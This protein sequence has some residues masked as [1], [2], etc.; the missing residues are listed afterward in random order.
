MT[1]LFVLLA[2]VIALLSVFGMAGFASEADIA[3]PECYQSGDLNGDGEFNTKDAIYALYSGFFGDE[4]Y[5][6]S[7]DWDFDGNGK[8]NSRDAIELLYA[9]YGM[10]DK[11]STGMVHD[12]HDPVWS[13]NAAGDS[14]S[15]SVTF[16]CGCQDAVTVVYG[17]EGYALS[18]Q[19]LEDERVEPGCL[20]AGTRMYQAVIHYDGK[21]YTSRIH[22]VAVPAKG[23]TTNGIVAVEGQEGYHGQFCAECQSY[24]D[25]VEHDWQDAG[26][27][28][29]EMPCFKP[30]RQTYVCAG[31]KAEKT[32]D[33]SLEEHNY[34]YVENGDTLADSSCC[35]YVK[36]YTCSVCPAEKNPEQRDYY[37]SHDFVATDKRAATCKVNGALIYTC[38]HCPVQ[39]EEFILSTGEEHKWNEGTAENGVITYTC[40]EDGCGK[41]K[42]AIVA[43]PDGAVSKDALNTSGEVELGNAT[44]DL[45]KVD[46][47]SLEEE[48]KL[49]VGTHDLDAVL[50]AVGGDAAAAK[51]DIKTDTVY[52]FSMTNSQGMPVQ[53][54]G[55]ITITMPYELAEG[56]DIT[57]IG[58][59]YI[60]E[61]GSLERISATWSDGSITF[62]VEHFSYYTVRRLTPAERC[63]QYGHLWTESTKAATCLVD[64]YTKQVCQ[65]CAAEQNAVVLPA[66]GSHSYAVNTEAGK[67]AT[68]LVDGFPLEECSA[69]GHQKR[70]IVKATGHTMQP[71]RLT[72]AKCGVDGEFVTGCAD[73]EYTKTEKL[74]ALVH[75]YGTEPTQ[76]VAATCTAGGYEV[77]TCV[78]CTG[79]IHKNETQPTGHTYEAGENA[80]TWSEDFT[81]A[82]VTLTCHCGSTKELKAVATVSKGTCTG[83]GSAKVVISYNNKVFSDERV[84]GSAPGHTAGESWVTNANQHYHLCAVCGDK[85]DIATHNYGEGTETKAP[86]C[87]EPGIESFF[88]GVCGYEKQQT[89][90][91]TGKHNYVDGSCADCGTQ[92]SACDHSKLYPSQFDISGFDICQGTELILHSCS[93]GKVQRL[94]VKSEWACQLEV[95]SQRQEDNVTGVPT[96]TETAKCSKCG[97][98][99]E[100]SGGYSVAED[101][102]VMYY[103]E[104]GKLTLDG[105]V[106]IQFTY[107]YPDSEYRHPPVEVLEETKLGD[108]GICDGYVRKYTCPC[109]EKVQYRGESSCEWTT[110]EAGNSQCT[111]CGVLEMGESR[112]VE[113][114]CFVDEYYTVTYVLNG[115]TVFSYTNSYRSEN[116]DWKRTDVKLH[117]D[118]CTDGL[119]ITEVCTKC[120]EQ[121]VNE[122]EN[123]VCLLTDTYDLKEYGMCGGYLKQYVCP[124]GTTYLQQHETN[125]N[126]EYVWDEER[127]MEYRRCTSCGTIMMFDGSQSEP[128]E[129]CQY[130]N[131][132]SI[133]FYDAKMVELLRGASVYIS[134]Q[135]D[136]KYTMTLLGETCEDGVEMKGVCTRCGETTKYTNHYHEQVLVEHIDLAEQGLCGGYIE[137]YA[138]ACGEETSTRESDQCNWQW[139]SNDGTIE[140]YSC[141]NCGA[142]RRTTSTKTETIDSCRDKWLYVTVIELN[143]KEVA[144]SETEGMSSHHKYVYELQLN[145]GAT[146]CEGGYKYRQRCHACGVGDD[147]WREAGNFDHYT[148]AVSYTL[149][150]GEDLCGELWLRERRCACGKS[151]E[152]EAYW[153][154]NGC[155]FTNVD[156]KYICRICGV[157]RL[158]ESTKTLVEGTTC[159]YRYSSTYTFIK[160]GKKIASYSTSYTDTEHDCISS[161]EML[162]ETCADGYYVIDKCQNCD[163]SYKYEE[164]YTDCSSHTVE[165]R[166][167]VRDNSAICGYVAVCRSSCPCGANGSVYWSVENCDFRDVELPDGKGYAEQCIHC[168]LIR[169]EK[170]VYERAP[171][172]CQVK[173]HRYYTAILNGEEVGHAELEQ[174]SYQ[175]NYIYTGEFVEGGTSCTDGYY[176]RM[177]CARCGETARDDSLRYNHETCCLYYYDLSDYGLCGGTVEAYGCVCQQEIRWQYFNDCEWE[178]LGTD[179]E[180]GMSKRYCKTCNTYAIIDSRTEYDPTECKDKGF[181]ICKL[182]R[183]GQV[184]LDINAPVRKESH[185]YLM[186]NWTLYGADCEAGYEVDLVC[187]Y[188]GKTNTGGG[189][190]HSSYAIQIIDLKAQGACSGYIEV[191]R[192][193]CGKYD[194]VN[195]NNSCQGAEYTSWREDKADGYAHYFEQHLCKDCGLKRLEEYYDVYPEGS[196]EGTRYETISFYMGEVLLYT[197]SDEEECTEHHWQV[198]NCQL[199]NPNGDCESGVIVSQSC[200]FCGENYTYETNYHEEHVQERIDLSLYGS[201]CGGY[202]ER[203][204]CACGDNQGARLSEDLDCDL[205]RVEID[206]WLKNALRESQYTSEGQNGYYSQSYIYTC[207]VTD[208]QCGMKIRYFDGWLQ[209][210]CEAV[211]YHIWQLGYDPETNTWLKEVKVPTGQRRPF[212]SYTTTYDCETV[213][214]VTYSTETGICTCGSTYTLERWS[215]NSGVIK[216]VRTVTETSDKGYNKKYVE[217]TIYGFRGYR[218]NLETFEKYQYFKADGTEYWTQYEY[219]YLTNGTCGYKRVYTNSDGDTEVYERDHDDDSGYCDTEYTSCCQPGVSTT[220]WDCDICGEIVRVDVSY[221]EPKGHNWVPN[222]NGPGYVCDECGL[223]NSNGADG[224]IIFED[225][226]GSEGNG[227]DYVIGYYNYGEGS[228]TVYVSV[229]RNAGTEDEEEVVLQGI[230]PTFR[231]FETD[232]INAVCFNKEEVAQAA[233]AAFPEG[234][235]RIRITFVPADSDGTLDYAITLSDVAS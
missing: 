39:K 74:P 201:V 132:D 137:R 172:T 147:E 31:C 100:A 83:A 181:F 194:D 114:G 179:P 84:V 115:K 164:L 44:M 94:E 216:D 228:F 43:A 23:H 149:V 210:D 7:R 108:L 122:H 221:E 13:W 51:D 129:N 118:S 88:C 138:C 198:T 119:T 40:Q 28:V 87:L 81:N 70:T 217:T 207:A 57:D 8:H 160:D 190:G 170:S 63:Q 175:H 4:A 92:E 86:T 99:V 155:D 29:S 199:K 180:T 97:L 79:T 220:N 33:L 110:D 151:Q 111:V 91:A 62:T 159:S 197:G 154:D 121:Q 150:N 211:E 135:H 66:A 64:G 187:F 80:W 219:T 32:V 224:T 196:C 145:E 113:D 176:L 157:Q 183:D 82:T 25:V 75:N 208:P 188:C 22:A 76:V 168:G 203:Y 222:E 171:G 42:T 48:I 19:E 235:F 54:G 143:G 35:K 174:N 78:H 182:T 231:D 130:M 15:V 49:A 186:T 195:W 173:V 161:Y 2:V 214:G 163:Y 177:T 191:G 193:P 153:E 146:S 47:E 212:H 20:T 89:L 1:R 128:D 73:C 185:Y 9:F 120:G 14:V 178:W 234:D 144:R 109:G 225:L 26:I 125:C 162:G 41:H 37:I 38:A 101:E 233:Y 229:V 123:H 12:Y 202:L 200:K 103:T 104:Q 52:D 148:Y 134:W 98:I 96:V 45:S 58:V 141:R 16:K 10:S 230:T 227:I 30:S 69:C 226:T 50:E 71:V 112:F 65:R 46:K 11:I 85:V 215:D 192:C 105:E 117:G 68:C 124:C 116:H 93:C 133:I 24:V 127:N 169:T 218:D 204:T 53:F 131:Y 55:S 156:G 126:W 3:E 136:Y 27:V 18:I 95:V 165:R 142:T 223:E 6:I 56:E 232:G 205:D 102:C 152:T 72:E 61:D 139:E 213:D 158:I 34:Q 166:Y 36:H 106:L 206:N 77:Y 107:A 184:L 140:T 60:A 5:P 90:P 189:T 209:E 17:Q 167:L 67:A 59:Y 21:E